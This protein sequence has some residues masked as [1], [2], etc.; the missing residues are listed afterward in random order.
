MRSTRGTL[1]ENTYNGRK[2]HNERT[3]RA[4][5][6]R[7]GPTRPHGGRGGGLPIRRMLDAAR[8]ARGGELIAMGRAESIPRRRS[9]L[10]RVV[11][12]VIGIGVTAAVAYFFYRELSANWREFLEYD[13]NI[14]YGP[15][16]LSLVV[17][18]V[19]FAISP[20][21]WVRILELQGERLGHLAA[22]VIFYLANIG[23]Y[24]PGKLWG[25]GGQV[26]L[27]RRQ[28]VQVQHVIVSAA[29]LLI[30][31]YFAGMAFAALTLLFWPKIPAALAVGAA[32]AIAGAVALLSWSERALSLCKRGLARIRIT[33]FEDVPAGPGLFRV[34][35][36]LTCRWLLLGL[37]FV[38]GIKAIIDID[39][40]ES[41][42]YCGAF[43]LSHLLSM[44]VFVT[45]AGLGVREGLNVYF[46]EAVTALPVPIAI[47]VS[48]ATRLWMTVME[49]ICVLPALG[50]KRILK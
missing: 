27:T 12:S 8:R 25:Y 46:L 10:W 38:I 18:F 21:A 41:I 11:G 9:L 26:Y 39:V 20:L 5:V 29:V 34:W 49:L 48:V 32:A 40:V 35:I 1:G 3:R 28:G 17:L 44:L 14:R 30:L 31:D 7:S 24:I 22:F 19:V 16:A 43:T 33:A 13:W 50:V 23:K 45:P 36:F 47:G 6:R 4:T 37:A 42:A 15:V 2:L